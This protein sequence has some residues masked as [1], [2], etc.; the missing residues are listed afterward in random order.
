MV[1]VQVV[2]EDAPDVG[3]GRWT[4]PDFLLRDQITLDFIEDLGID[5]ISKI[6]TI[7]STE[8]RNGENAQT[9]FSQFKLKI[10]DKAK[11]REKCL[12]PR[13]VQQIRKL[14]DDLS[15]ILNDQLLTDLDQACESTRI[16][17]KMEKIERERHFK[18]RTS[19]QARNF[20]EG[21]TVSQYWSAVNEEVKPRDIFYALRKLEEVP[22][23]NNPQTA[24]L[25][26][27]D[28][29]RMAEL[30]RNYHAGL[31]NDGA[32]AEI[33][34]ERQ[35]NFD[36]ALLSIKTKVSASQATNLGAAIEDQ[37]ICNA[38]TQAGTAKSPGMDG[39]TYE[40]YK[41][42]LKRA[43]L[44]RNKDE[45][46]KEPFDIIEL[47]TLVFN[48]IHLHGV[49]STTHFTEGWMC[50]LYK[51]NDRNDISNYRPL[52]ILNTDY[53]MF[54]KVFA[55]RFAVFAPLVLHESQAG[56]VKGQQISDQTK[57]I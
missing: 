47:L 50:P 42:L 45:L 8:W 11:Q 26:E 22:V 20:L 5:T 2:H 24:D 54:T 57:L 29:Q 56:F 27:K 52:T 6:K 43:E 12:A 36:K 25:Y 10:T 48:D 53:K 1:S 33:S 46:E 9:L 13:T 34:T 39:I 3:K 41:T 40:V 35:E 32:E 7:Q 23:N 16:M 4:F 19:A 21:E 37:E 14:E 38:I 51:K 28:S 30:A 15:D 55:V 44:S 31:Q 49:D 18:E 17:E